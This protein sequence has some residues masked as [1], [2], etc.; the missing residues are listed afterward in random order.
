MSLVDIL[1]YIGI[2]LGGTTFGVLAMSLCYVAKH[3]H[4]VPDDFTGDQS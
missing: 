1:L 3:C 2:A 4:D